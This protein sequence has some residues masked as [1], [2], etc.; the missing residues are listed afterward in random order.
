MRSDLKFTFFTF[1]ETVRSHHKYC[2]Q[3]ARAFNDVI[4]IF[5]KLFTQCKYVHMY[6]HTYIRTYIHT[7]VHNTYIHT[8]VHAYIHT[9]EYYTCIKLNFLVLLGD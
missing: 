3:S 7:Y 6:I 2:A 9:N 5:G 8:H 1:H 4:E